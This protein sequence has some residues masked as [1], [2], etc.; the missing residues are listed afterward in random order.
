MKC[1]KA[2]SAFQE[3]T[4]LGQPFLLRSGG[5][6]SVFRGLAPLVRSLWDLET[7]EGLS[8]LLSCFHSDPDLRGSP[9]EAGVK[10]GSADAAATAAFVNK[11]LLV[12]GSHSHLWTHCLQALPAA[13]FPVTSSHSLALPR[14]RVCFRCVFS[15]RIVS[16]KRNRALGS[17]GG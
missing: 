11:V 4:L 17:A 3:C 1:G 14:F 10:K 8:F 5:S 6:T 7:L 2:C 15:D 16:D 12:H 13:P 9:F